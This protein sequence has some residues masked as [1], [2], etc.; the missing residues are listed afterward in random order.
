[1][2]LSSTSR[3]LNNY[4]ISSLGPLSFQKKNISSPSLIMETRQ[5]VQ[6][7]WSRKCTKPTCIWHGQGS[8]PKPKWCVDIPAVSDLE[9]CAV[10]AV[11][12]IKLKILN[13]ILN[14][15]TVICVVK[16]LLSL[17]SILMLILLLLF[18]KEIF[19]YNAG[20]RPRF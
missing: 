17:S 18:K 2:S 10:T 1:M 14:K 8:G 15:Q 4:T 11:I 19:E 20:K 7:S 16:I 9:R 3:R 6:I 5:F 12:V 13:V